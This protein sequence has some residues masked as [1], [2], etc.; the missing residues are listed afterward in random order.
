MFIGHCLEKN[1]GRNQTHFAREITVMIVVTIK[2][3]K[4]TELIISIFKLRVE[5]KTYKITVTNNAYIHDKFLK[6]IG[7]L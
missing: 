7:N 4:V 2:I 5:A 1:S 6:N 3:M